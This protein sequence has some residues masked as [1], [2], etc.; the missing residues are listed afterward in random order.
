MEVQF[1]L[2]F[3]LDGGEWSASC[4]SCFTPG[5]RAPSND[6]MGGY[7]CSCWQLNPGDPAHGLV[8]ILTELSQ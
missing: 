8:S 7:H 3:A 2:T 1:L 4:P 6:W 5:I